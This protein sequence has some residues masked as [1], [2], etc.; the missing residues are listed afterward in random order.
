M[1]MR[2]APAWP[3]T[4][5]LAGVVAIL[6]GCKFWQLWENLERFELHVLSDT[7]TDELAD[8]ESAVFSEYAQ[9]CRQARGL[10]V[11]YRRRA[12]NARSSDA[13]RVCRGDRAGHAPP[14][15]S[16]LRDAPPTT[17]LQVNAS[18]QAPAH[19]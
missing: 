9:Y 7:Q 1:R 18:V 17:E 14:R 13:S 19:M 4:P 12:D 16:I 5:E 11:R 2:P 15:Q 6:V 3:G 10:S 8:E